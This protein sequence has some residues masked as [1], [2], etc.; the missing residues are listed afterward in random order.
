[1]RPEVPGLAKLPE[2]LRSALLNFLEPGEHPLWVGQSGPLQRTVHDRL[3]T[4]WLVSLT[5]LGIFAVIKAGI[6][7][8]MEGIKLWVPGGSFSLYTQ[9]ASHGL[10]TALGLAAFFLFWYAR[11]IAPKRR[12][13]TV[14]ALTSTRIL[15]FEEDPSNTYARWFVLLHESEV[16]VRGVKPDGS[17]D[18]VFPGMMIRGC[19][20]GC[21]A[22][23]SQIPDAHGVA[24]L[25]LE[26]AVA[27][28]PPESAF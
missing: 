5:H 24:S 20:H 4:M 11:A 2:D 16:I 19:T 13:A 22:M 1:M 18:V 25:I 26:A 21:D 23:F 15:S 17:G 3:H 28:T 6:A 8:V 12:A 7:G 27:A 10:F 9:I 14:Y